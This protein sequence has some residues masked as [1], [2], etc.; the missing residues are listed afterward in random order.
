MELRHRDG[1]VRTMSFALRNNVEAKMRVETDSTTETKKVSIL[2]NF[3][4]T[5]NMNFDRPIK[6]S[7]D[8]HYREYQA[9][10]RQAEYELQGQF[11]PY[12]S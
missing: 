7:P 11:D 12:A 4:F 9:S 1:K 3:N 10:E 5:T 2:D 8:K 6:F